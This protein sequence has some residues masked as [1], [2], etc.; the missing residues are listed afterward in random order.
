[1]VR[2]KIVKRIISVLVAICMLASVALIVGKSPQRVQASSKLGDISFLR[3][4]FF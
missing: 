4:W 3:P 1:M 2:P